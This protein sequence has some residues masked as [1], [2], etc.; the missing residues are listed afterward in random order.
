MRTAIGLGLLAA[1]LACGCSAAPEGDASA[2]MADVLVA[3]AKAI[4]GHRVGEVR[5]YDADSLHEQLDG[6]A[7]S[8]LDSG[9]IRLAYAQWQAQ[10]ATGS[11]YVEME[12]YD[13][14]SPSGALD[15]LADD[16]SI[17]SEYLNL[18]DETLRTDAGLEMRAGRY[19]LRLTARKEISGQQ[20]FVRAVAQAVAQA[21]PHGPSDARLAAPLPEAGMVPHTV[22]F[23]LHGFLGRDFLRG[24]RLASYDVRGKRIQ[25]FALDA[26]SIEEATH[27]LEQW[28]AA[29]PPAPIGASVELDRLE[30]TEP[31]TGHVIV[32]RKGLWVAGAIGDAD[33]SALLLRTLAAEL[34]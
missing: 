23:V 10:G 3:A 5:W 33:A 13:M 19:F 24:V 34:E 11:A 16:R 26:A 25:L 30:W 32:I 18:G 15:I 20:E 12:L 8:Y 1:M 29:L 27:I 31:N 4:P 22:N 17:R 6:A 28:R 21:A 9:F 7:E 2:Q 14:G